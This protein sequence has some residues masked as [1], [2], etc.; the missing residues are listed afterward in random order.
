MNVGD[1][2]GNCWIS[3]FNDD[4]ELILGMTAKELGDAMAADSDAIADITSKAHFKQFI[5][6]CRAKM[7]TYNV[8]GS[9][10]FQEPTKTF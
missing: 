1:W 2:S 8:S 5:F 10:K 3:V 7:E 4:A 6:K 9:T